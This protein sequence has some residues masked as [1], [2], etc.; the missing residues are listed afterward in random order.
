MLRQSL[1]MLSRSQKVKGMVTGL[2]VS[3]GIVA[4]YV[5]GES[6]REAVEAVVGLVGS[7]RTVT[8][9]FLGE[10][11][12]DEAQA[13]ATVAAYLDLLQALSDRGLAA[14]AEVSVKLSAV[15]Q[16]LPLFGREID[17]LA[18]GVDDDEV[19]AGAVHLGKVQFHAVQSCCW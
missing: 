5:P 4:R 18:D 9:D 17:L 11:T 15:G 13:E 19:V 1:L 8:L 16:A 2:P 6:T 12:L 7:G 10:D 3:A 14:E